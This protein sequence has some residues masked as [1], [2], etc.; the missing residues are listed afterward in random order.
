MNEPV[1]ASAVCREALPIVVRHPVATVAPA[2]FL[3]PLS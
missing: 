2:L 1:R 3:A